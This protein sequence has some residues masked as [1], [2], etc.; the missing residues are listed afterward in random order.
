MAGNRRR[1]QRVLFPG[2]IPAAG[3]A[4]DSSN[5]ACAASIGGITECAGEIAP[6]KPDE[7]MALAN[8]QARRAG[9]PTLGHINPLIYRLAGR[10]SSREEVFRDV[11]RVGNDLGELIGPEYLGN[12]QPVGCCTAGRY[13][14]LASGWGSVRA[15]EFSSGLRRLA[16]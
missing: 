7:Y 14:D 15:P 8:Q 4:L 10:K 6:A 5:G 11:T 2:E 16:D 9:Q 3:G 1:A 12:N 13:F